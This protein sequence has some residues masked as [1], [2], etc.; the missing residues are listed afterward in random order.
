MP[1]AGGFFFSSTISFELTWKSRKDWL[2]DEIIGTDREKA[3]F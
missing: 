2:H 3:V 1:M